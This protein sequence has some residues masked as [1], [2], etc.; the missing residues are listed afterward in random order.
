MSIIS[1]GLPAVLI[2]FLAGIGI[3]PKNK[4]FKNC[5]DLS[6]IAI[7]LGLGL[8]GSVSIFPPI[9]IKKGF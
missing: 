9:S 4:V 1:T 3:A 2:I 6:C 8:P 5:I 7:A